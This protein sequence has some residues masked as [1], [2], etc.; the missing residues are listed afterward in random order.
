MTTGKPGAAHLCFPY[1]VMKQQ[2]DASDVWAQPEHGQF[3]S[4]RFAPDPA[5]VARAAQRL[6]G[7]RAPVIICGGGVVIAG[8]S[9]GRAAWPTR[10]R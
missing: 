7:A 3:P 10:I 8:A 2:V 4:M 6:G 5:D 1:D 9:A